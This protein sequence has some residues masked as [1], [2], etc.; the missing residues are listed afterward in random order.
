MLKRTLV[1][2]FRS[3]DQTGEK[4]KDPALKTRNYKLSRDKIWDEVTSVLRNSGYKVLHEVKSVGEIVC[5]KR[6]V[7]GRKLDI[8][9]TL[10]A[11]NPTAT[12]VDIYSASRGSLGD[13]GANYRTIL[14]I[15]SLLDRKLA[16]Y[17]IT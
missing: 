9:L 12:A 16:A 8:T 11:L 5:E 3:H 7:S 13:L 2:I 17:K 6:T 15:Y 10:F 1:G 4:A 14:Q